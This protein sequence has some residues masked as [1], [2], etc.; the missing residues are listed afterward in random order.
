MKNIETR[1]P[2]PE[3]WNEGLPNYLEIIANLPVD[4]MDLLLSEIRLDQGLS[5]YYRFAEEDLRKTKPDQK[6]DR[7]EVLKNVYLTL[8]SSVSPAGIKARQKM[9]SLLAEIGA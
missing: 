5:I 1:F 6:D 8:E 2:Q 3:D 9:E 4:K 7:K